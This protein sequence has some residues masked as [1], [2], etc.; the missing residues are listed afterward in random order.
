MS[1]SSAYFCGSSSNHDPPKGGEKDLSKE[2]KL[3]AWYTG[4]Y[5]QIADAKILK[6]R[7]KL[8]L[9][10]FPRTFD[11]LKELAEEL[12][13]VLFPIRDRTI[14]RGTLQDHKKL[15][16]PIVAAF[17]NAIVKLKGKT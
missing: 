9:D 11:G 15:Y 2:S 5:E 7:F 3:R 12:R 4:S 10:D 17:D 1:L 13:M 6:D 14:F 8:I 16:M